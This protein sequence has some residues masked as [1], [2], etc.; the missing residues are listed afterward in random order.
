MKKSTLLFAAL[1]GLASTVFAQKVPY[2]PDVL[3]LKQFPADVQK[4]K[5]SETKPAGMKTVYGMIMDDS[6][7][8]ER[9]WASFNS[10][11]PN[12]VTMIKPLERPDF[13]AS[14]AGAY[15]EGTYYTY[16]YK[17]YTYETEPLS[18]GTVDVNTG[19]Y[20]RVGDI[21]LQ[22]NDM[23]ETVYSMTY[24]NT[25]KKMYALYFDNDYAKKTSTCSLATVDL[26]TGKYTPIKQLQNSYFAIAA[27]Y[28]GKLYAIASKDSTGTNLYQLIPSANDVEEKLLLEIKKEDGSQYAANYAQSIT[29]DHTNWKLYWNSNDRSLYGKPLWSEVDVKT[30]VMKQFGELGQRTQMNSLYIPYRVADAP[31]APNC[32]TDLKAVSADNGVMNVDLSWVNP[33]TSWN[34]SEL[35]TLTAIDIYRGTTLIKTLDN[36]EKGKAMTFTD[37]N[38]PAGINTYKLVTRRKV[39]ENGLDASISCFVG[40]DVPGKVANLVLAASEDGKSGVL[41]WDE[42]AAGK[43]SGWYDKSSLKYTIT[44]YP[45]KVVVAKDITAKTFTDNTIKSLDFYSYNVL[46]S[47]VQGTGVETSSKS[48]ALGP[49][50]SIPYNVLFDSERKAG[51]WTVVD[52]DNNGYTWTYNKALKTFISD[53]TGRAND[54]L[55]SPNFTLEQ[56]KTYRVAFLSRVQAL[57]NDGSVE[58]VTFMMGQGKTVAAMKDTLENISDMKNLTEKYYTYTVTPKTTG[59]YNFGL[60]CYSEAGTW[61]IWLMGFYIE[62]ILPNDMSATTIRGSHEA[63]VKSE[64]DYTVGV[65]NKGGNVASGY[66]VQIIDS[67]KNV[68]AETTEVPTLASNQDSSVVVKWTPAVELQGKVMSIFGRVV[69]DKDVN[70]ANNVTTD[71]VSVKFN[72][73]DESTWVTTTFDNTWEK[74]TT[75]VL[76]LN[77]MSKTS[78]SQTIYTPAQLG[79]SGNDTYS[80]SKLSYHYNF[81]LPVDAVFNVYLGTTDLTDFGET[82]KKWITKDAMTQ[83]YSGTM[84]IPTGESDLIIKF[85]APFDY[86]LTKNLVVLVERPMDII[87]DV[88]GDLFTCVTVPGGVYPSIRYSSDS[89]QFDW[90][91]TTIKRSTATP[92][93]PVTRFAITKKYRPG[94]KDLAADSFT[95]NLSGN[96]LNIQANSEFNAATLY[97]MQGRICRSLNPTVGTKNVSMDI[98]GLSSGVYVLRVGDKAM[99]IVIK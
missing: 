62:E 72:E 52:P 60:H 71:S 92:L 49:N 68:L 8:H 3:S 73:P 86:D 59:T 29:F 82:D 17:Q 16:I 81:A 96:M 1:L 90:S 65:R 77:F 5:Q 78:V 24:D 76:P 75:A 63:S 58:S 19:V 38:A 87:G 30:G 84:S 99:K 15:A 95:Y 34:G 11:V 67:L 37:T 32:V 40:K 66:K 98:A 69:W 43:D 93:I 83:V 20:T 74:G 88:Y 70:P 39:G 25:N 31:E 13:W 89:K 61:G 23:S 9:G 42:P 4:V 57:V 21:E 7:Y 2:R 56:G 45:D 80:I 41:S 14:R 44:R 36:P 27:D 46:P 35:A 85:S 64:I 47:N 33:S 22:N 97:D 79:L 26:A 55:F 50:Q 10:F 6:Q 91:E 12:H 28:S 53:N 54:W 51:L 94:V 18:F 48:V